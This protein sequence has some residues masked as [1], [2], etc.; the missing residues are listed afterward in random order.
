MRPERNPGDRCGVG[1]VKQ[2]D[3]FGPAGLHPPIIAAPIGQTGN[4]AR[5]S[6]GTPSVGPGNYKSAFHQ[7]L[8][9]IPIWLENL[10]THDF[11]S[12]ETEDALE[13]AANEAGLKSVLYRPRRNAV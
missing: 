4:E 7:R 2:E 1:A 8:A 11:N 5:T 10:I 12:G 3:I 6:Q 9:Y 13:D